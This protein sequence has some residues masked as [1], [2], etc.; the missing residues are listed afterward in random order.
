VQPDSSPKKYVLDT[1]ALISGNVNPADP[2]FLIPS[3]VIS[4]IRHG[5]LSMQ[6][7]T[8]SETLSVTDPSAAAVEQVRK[9]ARESGDLSK[10]SSTDVDVVAVAMEHGGTVVTDDFAI[11]NVCS[12]LRIEFIPSGKAPIKDRVKWIGKCSGC[13]KTYAQTSGTCGICGHQIRRIRSSS[14]KA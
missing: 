12:H 9:K 3:S 14:R 6:L 2:S 11:Q 10:M 5:N 4:E 7:E 1:S 13:G 8:L